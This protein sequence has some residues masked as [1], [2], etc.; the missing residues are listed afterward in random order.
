MSKK[1]D[2]DLISLRLQSKLGIVDV[3]EHLKNV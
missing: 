1:N 3:E 2:I